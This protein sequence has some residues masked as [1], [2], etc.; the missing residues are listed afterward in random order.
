MY[1]YSFKINMT[2]MF[3]KWHHKASQGT[4]TVDIESIPESTFFKCPYDPVKIVNR[5]LDS[6]PCKKKKQTKLSKS[7][8]RSHLQR[9]YEQF[10][11]YLSTL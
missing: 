2:H 11:A 9:E 5:S 6:C 8:N 3:D 1:L 7:I 4:I 10:D